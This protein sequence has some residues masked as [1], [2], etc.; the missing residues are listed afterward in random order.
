MSRKKIKDPNVDVL[1][2]M[3][4]VQV[5]T[6][7]PVP[8]YNRK[9][10][11]IQPNQIRYYINQDLICIRQLNFPGQSKVFAYIGESVTIK[12]IGNDGQ[13]DMSNIDGETAT[14]TKQTIIGHFRT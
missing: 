8:Y 4:A 5:G 12:A 11:P 7:Q 2:H 13:S 1:K 3:A 14:F 10:Q 9:S 6:E